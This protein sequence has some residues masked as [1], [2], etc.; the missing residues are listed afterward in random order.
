MN[1]D[2]KKD[3]MKEEKTAKCDTVSV[4]TFVSD[5]SFLR[6]SRQNSRSDVDLVG[7]YDRLPHGI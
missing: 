4:K 5:S 6:T 1:Q 3:E 2:K 7:F